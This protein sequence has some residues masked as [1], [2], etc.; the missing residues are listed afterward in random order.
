VHR[1]RQS[2]TARA[3]RRLPTGQ[4]YLAEVVRD[5]LQPCVG[6]DE[7]AL[8]S[9]HEGNARL[10]GHLHELHRLSHV[11]GQRLLF[12]QRQPRLAGPLDHAAVQ[13]MRQDGNQSVQLHLVDHLVVVGECGHLGSIC[14][15]VK[16]LTVGVGHGGEGD[17]LGG[18]YGADV[19]PPHSADTDHPKFQVIAHNS[20]L[21]SSHPLRTLGVYS[22][23]AARSPAEG[24]PVIAYSAAC[25]DGQTGG[26][27]YALSE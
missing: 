9:E 12:E 21:L 14:H 24:E 25:S 27:P 18:L 22:P 3:R 5:L 19:A 10:L 1:R 17:A 16:C 26:Y 15:G 6:G 7:P 2:P 23:S 4:E 11:A 8:G 20:L 13:V